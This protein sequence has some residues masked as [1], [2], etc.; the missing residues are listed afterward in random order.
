MHSRKF[1]RKSQVNGKPT[2]G[3][4]HSASPL[5]RGHTAL[6][7]LASLL[8]VSWFFLSWESHHRLSLLLCS[9]FKLVVTSALT[10][11]PTNTLHQFENDFRPARQIFGLQQ[12]SFSGLST[13]LDEATLSCYFIFHSD[14]E[15]FVLKSS[16]S[17]LK[18]PSQPRP[19]FC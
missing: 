13:H 17:H 5:L 6:K 8:L 19:C 12:Q 2:L 16:E 3:N 1:K 11:I 4:R 9:P 14:E 10:R 15:S 18:D 7:F